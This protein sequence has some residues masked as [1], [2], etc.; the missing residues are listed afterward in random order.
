MGLETLTK[1]HEVTQGQSYY[2]QPAFNI[3]RG[4]NQMKDTHANLEIQTKARQAKTKSEYKSSIRGRL[5]SLPWRYK[6]ALMV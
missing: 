6:M 1:K 2:H 4:V 3:K 5:R